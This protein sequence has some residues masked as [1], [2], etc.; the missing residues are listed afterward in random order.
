MAT[1]R[2]TLVRL[3]CG[4]GLVTGFLLMASVFVP[5]FSHA[6]STDRLSSEPRTAVALDPHA[7]LASLGTIEDA[8]YRI[9]IYSG[10]RE[11]WY[12]VFDSKSDRLLASLLTAR[13]LGE[14]FPDLDI[15][16]MEFGVPSASEDS[17]DSQAMMLAEPN[18]ARPE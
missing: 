15:K 13:E 10:D 9:E 8:R 5:D 18:H 4:A 12:S 2:T 7:G 16:Q 1:S 3:A 6:D 14:A 17:P 11:P